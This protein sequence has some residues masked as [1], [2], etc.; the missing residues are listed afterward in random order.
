MEARFHRRVQS[1]LNGI[2]KRYDAVSTQLGDDFFAEFQV[3]LKRVLKEPRHFHFDSS[4]L[5]RYN[6]ERFPYHL[7]YDIR[8]DYVRV[9]VL[10]H[11]RRHPSFGVTRFHQ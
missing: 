9:W 3:G 1:D 2:I 10:R 6:L 7:L 11:H 5:R 4:G 8:S